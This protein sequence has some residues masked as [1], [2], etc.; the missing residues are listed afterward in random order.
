MNY[1]HNAF[2]VYDEENN[3]YYN[4]SNICD[5]HVN[6]RFYNNNLKSITHINNT[7]S[8]KQTILY[9]VLPIIRKI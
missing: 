3:E 9:E 4:Y 7:L 6:K 5:K 8:K 2:E 1:N